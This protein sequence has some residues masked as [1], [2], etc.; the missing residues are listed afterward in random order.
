MPFLVLGV[1]VWLPEIA[2]LDLN[3]IMRAIYVAREG[4]GAIAEA[5]LK[6]LDVM[7]VRRADARKRIGTDDP[8]VVATVLGES[9]DKAEAK[10]ALTK[11]DGVRLVPSDKYIVRSASGSVNQFPK[12]LAYWLQSKS[13]SSLVSPDMWGDLYQ[14]A[15]NAA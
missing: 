2:Q 5:A 3:H 6:A 15:K 8:I 9:L 12:M 10:K 13:A 7:M 11:L 1:L 4:E 14:Q